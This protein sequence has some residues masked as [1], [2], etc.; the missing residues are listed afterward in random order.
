MW[1]D[2]ETELDFLDYNYLVNS[3]KDIIQN[4]DLLP[5]CIGLYGDWGSGKSSLIRMCKTQLEAD[6]KNIK[7]LIF[8]GWLFENYEDAKTAILGEILDV[9]K[10]K[11]RLTK[12][13]KI[14]LSTLYKS[15]DKFKLVKNSLK[16]G[17]DIFLTGGI[18]TIAGL[19]INK[20]LGVL[21]NTAE[22][23][24][25]VKQAIKDELDYKELREDIREFQNN[26]EKLLKESKISR[27]VVFIDELDRCR[28][29]TILD[30][31]EAI[32]LFLFTGKTAFVLGADE[33]HI[34]YA[35]K[36]KFKDIEG[37]EI[38][39]GK[40]YLEKLV[41]YPI[42]IPRLDSKEIETY[43][44]FLLLQSEIDS[45]SFSVIVDSFHKVQSE[46]F[47][48]ASLEDVISKNGIDTKDSLFIAHQV[49]SLL[50][51]G[52]NG[53]PRQCKRF[54]NMMD[55]RMK[56]ASYKNKS[57]DR[58]ILVKIMMLEYFRPDIFRKFASMV[59]DGVL[60][61]ELA[62]IEKITSAEQKESSKKELK[63]LNDYLN[64]EWFMSWVLTEPTLS[65]EDL[66]IYFYF[67]RTSLEERLSLLITSL[68]P[69]AREIM[70][71]LISKAEMISQKA[72]EEANTDLATHEVLLI[73]DAI[74]NQLLTD[75][76]V[77]DIQMKS[78]C[79]LIGSKRE[80][81]D[82]GMSLLE[83]FTAEQLSGSVVPPIV[84][85]AKK[86]AQVDRIEKLCE[87][88]WSSKKSI[89][90][91]IANLLKEE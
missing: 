8:N 56:Q 48:Q 81:W 4:D 63:L 36:S 35:V 66:S 85:F 16:L 9:I 67:A 41:Q 40:E 74:A 87:G 5:A 46:D 64:D 50:T 55:L 52:L 59:I 61:R 91:M 79:N 62:T 30:T 18:G 83:K 77:N 86:S 68:S 90:K 11:T 65:K 10:A 12:K 45:K 51:R 88:K 28:P 54:L 84:E 17:A 49:S 6:D 38:D 34:S 23:K 57:L 24:T 37:Q 75:T 21:D 73:I 1:K 78:F 26:F 27:L 3:V 13:A 69:R 39:I 70:N 53:N 33:R 2:S 76:Q 15:V 14:I 29:D 31:L 43:I 72:I 44:G 89:V 47:M 7:C 58:R 22:E 71:K 60:S 42:K 82:K 25:D 19:A 80:Y 20:S 32:K